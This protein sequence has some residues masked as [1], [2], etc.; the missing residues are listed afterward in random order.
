MYN[1]SSPR[2]HTPVSV[3]FVCAWLSEF[4]N[5]RIFSL[6]LLLPPSSARPYPPP[7]S[8][9]SLLGRCSCLWIVKYIAGSATADA[10]PSFVKRKQSQSRS[11]CRTVN[12]AFNTRRIAT[13]ETQSEPALGK[14]S[15]DDESTTYGSE[16]LT[17]LGSQTGSIAG[18]R[19]ARSLKGIS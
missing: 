19:K 10:D 11:R 4:V 12:H 13:M 2:S 1:L 15:F 5:R 7:P 8:P 9:S 3:F 17:T 18:D 6:L 14:R 16:D